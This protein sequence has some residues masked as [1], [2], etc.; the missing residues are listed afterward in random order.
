MFLRRPVTYG[1][2]FTITPNVAHR[3]SPDWKGSKVRSD[4]ANLPI[5]SPAEGSETRLKCSNHRRGRLVRREP[6][7]GK[8]ILGLTPH[9][10]VDLI[11]VIPRGLPELTLA[12]S[13]PFAE[14]HLP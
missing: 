5:I 11:K 7:P 1:L 14:P 12:R 4:V 9:F 2:T 8:R 6:M 10:D 3:S 13:P